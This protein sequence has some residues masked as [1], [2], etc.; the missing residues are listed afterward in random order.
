MREKGYSGLVLVSYPCP[1]MHESHFNSYPTPS[2]SSSSFPQ[3]HIHYSERK[4]RLYGWRDLQ[5]TGPDYTI[6]KSLV[7]PD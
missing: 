7:E 1:Q 6:H 3:S 4:E 2:G 5:N